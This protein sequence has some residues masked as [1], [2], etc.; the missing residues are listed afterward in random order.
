MISARCHTNVPPSRGSAAI[1]PRAAPAGSG[2]TIAASAWR[3]RSADRSSGATDGSARALRRRVVRAP[4]ARVLTARA[5][6]RSRD[7][8]PARST[9]AKRRSHHAM[10]ASGEQWPCWPWGCRRGGGKSFLA[11]GD[12][13]GQSCPAVVAQGSWLRRLSRKRGG[14]RRSEGHEHDE[15]AERQRDVPR[16]PRSRGRRPRGPA[17][18]RPATGATRAGHRAVAGGR[19]ASG[20]SAPHLPPWRH[21]RPRPKAS[22]ARPVT[23]SIAARRIA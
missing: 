3:R 16:L 14:D 8:T 11:P 13:I 20:P 12:S 18:A 5:P 19:V 6:F 17:C 10:G 2:P 7:A 9:A 22:P 1:R 21:R 4:P 23:V 15:R